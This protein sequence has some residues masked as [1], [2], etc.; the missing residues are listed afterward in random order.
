MS[1]PADTSLEIV[2]GVKRYGG[3]VVLDRLDLL[4]RAGDR[5]V[6]L[7]PSGAGKST[8]LSVLG[9]MER[10]DGGRFLVDGRDFPDLTRR[11]AESY[12]N[13]RV[14]FVYQRHCLLPQFDLLENIMVP[15]LSAGADR[16]ER[17]DTAREWLVRAGLESR[18]GA[19]PAE[20][21]AG[22]SQRA[23]ILRAFINDPGFLLADEPTGSLDQATGHAI[24]DF[25]LERQSGRGMAL[26]I[27]THDREIA[28]RA[29][30]GGGR[31]LTLRD[32]V[33]HDAP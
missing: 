31:I 16:R 2:Q 22:E 7:G 19:R 9:G 24:L 5:L 1:G 32:G 25:L 30:A 13:K 6:I 29:A 27:V 18:A 20:V 8:L 12:R 14:G 15:V 17:L 23:A 11:E 21:S 33:L 10:L 28:A 4:V 26:V 3:R